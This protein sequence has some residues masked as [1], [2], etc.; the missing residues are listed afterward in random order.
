MIQFS[1]A[2]EVAKS[3]IGDLYKPIFEQITPNEVGKMARA[4]ALAREYGARLQAKSQNLKDGGLDA[5][6]NNYPDHGFV[7][8][9]EEAST[10]FHRLRSPNRVETQLIAALGD[11]ALAPNDDGA[12]IRFLS[13]PQ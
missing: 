8:D 6:V 13:Q 12:D 3:L 9:R 5:L 11:A 10:I 7:I 2:T 1:V 4:L